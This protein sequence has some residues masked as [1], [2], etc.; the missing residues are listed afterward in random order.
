[1]DKGWTW[2]NAVVSGRLYVEG[3]GKSAKI[4]CRRAFSKLLE[5]SGF[6]GRMP[7]IVACGT[8]NDAYKDFRTA[9][10][11]NGSA[12]YVGML[13]DSEDPV[14]DINAPWEHL[15]ARDG[16]EKPSGA[17]DDQALLMVTSM[18]TWIAADSEALGDHYGPGFRANA[19]PPITN[20]ESRVRGDMLAA[21]ENAT[22]DCQNKY[23]K[24][25]RSYEVLGRVNPT[26]LRQHLPSFDRAMRIL[27]DKL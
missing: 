4:E 6:A 16:W 18:E 14:A 8:R 3:G 11:G 2:R 5:K 12:R 13:V 22:R 7:G 10:A 9:H 23:A 27:D 26:T 21:L 15:H 19:L 20:L 24:G 17:T 25:R 1:M